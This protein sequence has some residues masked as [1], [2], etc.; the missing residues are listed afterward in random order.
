M[1]VLHGY[2]IE[3]VFGL[4]FNPQLNYSALDRTVSAKVMDFFTAFA[5][6]G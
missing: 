1:D 2:E 4:P 5:E 6:T 3:L